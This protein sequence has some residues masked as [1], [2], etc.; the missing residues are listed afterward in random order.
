VQKQIDELSLTG[1][2]R[3]ELAALLKTE[4][5]A[6]ELLAE[7]MNQLSTTH[8]SGR[9]QLEAAIDQSRDA[10]DDARAQRQRIVAGAARNQAAALAKREAAMQAQIAKLEAELAAMARRQQAIVQEVRHLEQQSIGLFAEAKSL[11]RSSG[12]LPG[13]IR[14]GSEKEL[15][16]KYGQLDPSII[17]PAAEVVATWLSKRTPAG[18]LPAGDHIILAWDSEGYISYVHAR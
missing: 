14:A 1:P 18:P 7:Q 11:A 12:I 8:G 5:Q 15:W 3:K 13:D 6:S 2:Q 16:E 17:A 10:I 9:R 4:R